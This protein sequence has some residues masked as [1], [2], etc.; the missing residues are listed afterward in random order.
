M[1]RQ[2]EEH[3]AVNNYLITRPPEEILYVNATG[4]GFTSNQV[5]KQPDGSLLLRN[6]RRISFGLFGTGGQD[7][8]GMQ[9]TLITE[10]H[11]GMTIPWFKVIE[12]KIPGGRLSADQIRWNGIMKNLGA[13]SEVLVY[14]NGEYVTVDVDAQG[15]R[16]IR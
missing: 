10:Q 7:L 6:P 14:K 15:T 4:H 5:Y 16:V 9:Q 2:Q 3:R 13:I 8:I 11:I 1:S 12:M